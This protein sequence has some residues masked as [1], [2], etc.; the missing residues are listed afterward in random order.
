[1]CV[2]A[3]VSESAVR[4]LAYVQ[5]REHFRNHGLYLGGIVLGKH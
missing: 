4:K 1:M 3:P 5:F 2:A